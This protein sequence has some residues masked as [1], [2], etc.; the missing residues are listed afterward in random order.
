MAH[1]Q[2]VK[3]GSQ[4]PFDLRVVP[5]NVVNGIR[6]LAPSQHRTAGVQRLGSDALHYGI[7]CRVANLQQGPQ[8]WRSV[9][10]IAL[11][12]KRP[13][14]GPNYFANPFAINSSSSPGRFG[15][16]M[17][18]RYFPANVKDAGVIINGNSSAR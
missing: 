6:S 18:L 7:D 3:P 2:G 15:S 10:R 8:G 1:N 14:I 4:Q 5:V 13:R 11:G 12:H 9:E 17:N 16:Q